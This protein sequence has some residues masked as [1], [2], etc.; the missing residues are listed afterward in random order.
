MSGSL[1]QQI[2]DLRPGDHV[3]SIDEGPA[4]QLAV[5]A[6]F[7]KAGLARGQRCVHVADDRTLDEVRRALT[8][9]GVDVTRE[10]ERGALWLL[11]PRDTY[12]RDGEFRPAVML[13]FVRRLER[14]ALEDGFSGLWGSGEMTWALG[15]E[16]GCDRLIEYEAL[17][18]PMTELRRSVVLCQYD[19]ALFGRPSIHDVLRAHSGGVLRA[20]AA[21]AGAAAESGGGRDELY[22]FL[23]ENTHD[24][25][26]LHDVE[27]HLVYQSPSVRRLLGWVPVSPEGG[28]HPDDLP[29]ALEV[30]RRALTGERTVFA[31]RHAHADGSWRW[32]ETS[33]SLVQFRGRPHLLAVTRDVTERSRA[34]EALRRSERV[35]R[36]A[37]MLG[38]TGSSEYCVA[39]KALFASEGCLRNY[40]GGGA[41]AGRQPED[42]V[43]AIHP[44]DRGP[45]VRQ[46]Q[47]L[48]AEGGPRE[49]EFRVV[50]PDGSVHVLSVRATVVRDVSGRP[51]R[52]F[53]TS[54]DITERKR[55]EMALRESAERLQHLSR[56][57]FAVQEEE[58]GHL[59]RELH[60]EFGQ[61]LTGLRLLL[62][63]DGDAPAETVRARIEQARSIAEELLERVRALSFDLRPAALDQLG[64][65]PA[66]LTLGEWYTGQTGVR[67]DFKHQGV[68]GRFPPEVETAA[69]RVVQEALTNAARHAG[70]DRVAVRVWTRAEALRVQV[71]DRGRGFDAEA[72]L[73][74]PRSGGLAGMRERVLLLGGRLTIESR[75]G[76]GSQVTAELPLPEPEGPR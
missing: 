76:A 5:T 30:W 43:G 61:L 19:E 75:L 22:R 15:R 71:E 66:L 11:T 73:A 46:W 51:V 39:T 54:L 65:L 31:Y 23:M 6:A 41:G 29:A 17:L 8:A 35:L 28:V 21:A 52:V 44:D 9:A 70:V 53:G 63:P 1:E 69:Y 36:E 7:V 48:L 64:L 14:Q 49:S 12:L 67:I 3:C 13:Q 24:V 40:F 27:G 37:E 33:G 4:E 20:D 62:K 45:T 55:S 72:A 16:P 74:A 2:A 26:T 47:Q 50:W 10:Q 58:R 32:L 18:D 56:R 59:A 38:R 25:V 34:E 42:F 60:D 57:L 68:L